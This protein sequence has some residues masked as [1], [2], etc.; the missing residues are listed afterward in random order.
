MKLVSLFTAAK[1]VCPIDV[2][3]HHFP[4]EALL[5]SHTR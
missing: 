1:C 5:L 2:V 4:G 3:Y